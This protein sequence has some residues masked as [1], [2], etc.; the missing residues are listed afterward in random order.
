[1]FILC[2]GSLGPGMIPASITFS[3]LYR[4]G[5]GRFRITKYIGP[6]EYSG[7]SLQRDSEEQLD[8]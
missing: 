6:A 4:S 3:S 8:S 5:L 1:M 2:L 7:T